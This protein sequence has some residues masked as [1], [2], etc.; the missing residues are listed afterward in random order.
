MDSREAMLASVGAAVGGG[1]GAALTLWWVKLSLK[2]VLDQYDDAHKRHE[3]KLSRFVEKVSDVMTDIKT[4]LAV[5]EVRSAEIEVIKMSFDKNTR[6]VVALG[7]R[8]QKTQQDV[9]VAHQRIRM[10]GGG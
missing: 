10:M 3:E 1:G 6:E 5:M 9:A 7:V 8:L 4:K 2:R